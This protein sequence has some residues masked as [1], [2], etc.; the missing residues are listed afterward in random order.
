VTTATDVSSKRLYILLYS[1][2]RHLAELL[3]LEMSAEIEELATEDA[4]GAPASAVVAAAA[5]TE[6][7]GEVGCVGSCSL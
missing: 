2:P 4:A 1:Q 3:F 5:T 7:D 6:E